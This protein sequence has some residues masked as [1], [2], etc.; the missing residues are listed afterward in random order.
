LQSFSASLRPGVTEWGTAA[1][2]RLEIHGFLIRRAFLPTPREAAEPC[3]CQGSH[4]SL[5]RLALVALLER[6]DLGPKG[7][8]R[9]FHSPLA[10]RVAPARRP[11]E[12]PGAPGLLAAAFRHGRNTRISLECRD[13]GGTCPLCANG[14]QEARSKAGP[15]PG[16]ASHQGLA[17]WSWA[18]CARA[19]APSAIAPQGTRSGATRAGP[20]RGVGGMRPSSV[21]SATALVMAWRR[22]A[23][24][25]AARTGWARQQR[26]R[27][28]RGVVF[29][30]ACAL[31]F[32]LGGVVCGPAGGK[33]VTGLGP[34]TGMH[35]QEHQASIGAERGNPGPFLTRKAHSNGHPVARRAPGVAPRSDRVRAVLADEHRACPSAGGLYAELV[36]GSRPV[37][38]NAGGKVLVRHPR[39]VSPP[40]VGASATQGHACWRSAQ[41]CERAGSAAA[42]A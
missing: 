9:G 23:L 2:E 1:L 17:G 15:A 26:S 28:E 18:R 20:R 16:K 30:E 12:A 25:S 38:A 5:L 13:S 4:R 11:R 39:P 42:S 7:R 36:F 22:G 33:R 37:E 8:P 41:A 14:P 31:A 21:R 3:A 19:W 24:T 27:G 10:P 29:A 35:G 32:G 34:G 40:R 6:V